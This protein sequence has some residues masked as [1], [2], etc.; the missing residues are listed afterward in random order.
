M[1]A[2][3]ASFL[4]GT[5]EFLMAIRTHPDETHQLLTLTTD[6]IVDWLQY[7]KECLPSLEG[8][9]VLD[10]IVGFLGEEDFRNAVL[11]Y[12]KRIFGCLD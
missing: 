7:Q 10:D 4:L 3:I 6:F 12:L 9:F 8:V 1:G 2:V 5:T 11:P